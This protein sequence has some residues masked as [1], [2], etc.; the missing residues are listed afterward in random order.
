MGFSRFSVGVQSF[1]PSGLKVMTRD[2]NT[3]STHS[4]LSI[5]SEAKVNWSLDLIYGWHGQSH[6]SWLKDLDA[7]LAYKPPH[8]SMYS[9]TYEA[10]TPYALF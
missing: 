8:I 4:A 9:L 6:K 5:L 10:G 2:H 7:A 1:D 3:Q